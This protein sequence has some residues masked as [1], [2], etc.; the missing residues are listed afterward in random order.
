VS[1]RKWREQKIKQVGLN[2]FLL[3]SDDITID[4]L[5]DSGTNAMSENQWAALRAAHQIVR[6]PS[7][8]RFRK[9]LKCCAKWRLV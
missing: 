7:R 9:G 5:T 1:A 3:S 2:P 4:L 6:V 8:I